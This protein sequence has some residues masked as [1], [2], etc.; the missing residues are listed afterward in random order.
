M[1]GR[2]TSR[3]SDREL[4]VARLLADGRERAD[5]ASTLHRARSTVDAHVQNAYRKTGARTPAQLIL[6]LQGG[7][8]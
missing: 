1:T 3:L 8:Q 6:W 5:I 2:D 4:T 7:A